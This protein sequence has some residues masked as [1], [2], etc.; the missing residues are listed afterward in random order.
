MSEVLGKVY[1]ARIKW[2]D[3]GLQIGLKHPDL[4]AIRMRRRDDPDECFKELLSDWLN[5]M[6]P[7]PTW[8]ALTDAL[9]SPTVGLEQLAEEI[10]QS[11]CMSDTSTDSSLLCPQTQEANTKLELFKC[12]CSNCDL[13]SYLD[14]GCPKSKS[15]PY[16]YLRLDGLTPDD[17]EDVIQK[18][19]DDLTTISLSFEDLMFTTRQS[20]NSR[21]ISVAVLVSVTQGLVLRTSNINPLPM[22]DE[23]HK[24]LKRAQ[25]IDEV[26]VLVGSHM[27]FFN[28]EILGKIIKKLG[29]D[30]DKK[31]LQEYTCR[32]DVFCKR[33][34]FEVPPNVYSSGHERKNNKLFVVLAT[35]DL[36][37]TLSDVKRAQ[38][39]IASLFGFRASEIKLEL[40]DYGSVILTFSISLA[41]S[42][43]L[44]PLKPDLY[45]ALKSYG[46]IVIATSIPTRDR[47]K[48]S[49]TQQVC[50]SEIIVNYF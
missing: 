30:E 39:K 48:K 16:P 42:K 40:V 10:E 9:R 4:E 1:D 22:S 6:N 27:S 20:L 33:K 44:F 3:I 28:H 34:I 49:K 50:H 15:S 26:F 21:N 25:S 17:K 7:K 45:E 11:L 24:S 37:K 23:D 32:F 46:Y 36:I 47:S 2:H 19:S 12:P 41:L 13:L 38:R 5:R 18:L 31:K 14:S 35:E 8:S 29:D 43:D